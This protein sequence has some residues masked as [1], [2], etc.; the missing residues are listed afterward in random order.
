MG[1]NHLPHWIW[2][3][4]MLEGPQAAESLSRAGHAALS[5][6]L[7]SEPRLTDLHN[8][9]TESASWRWEVGGEAEGEE[10]D[11]E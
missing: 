5:Q 7:D 8:G 10:P 6:S 9:T 2:A 1:G 11:E 3:A 4:Q